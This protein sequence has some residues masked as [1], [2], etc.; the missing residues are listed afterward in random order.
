[1]AVRKDLVKEVLAEL[2]KLEDQVK[3]TG[4]YLIPFSSCSTVTSSHLEFTKHGVVRIETT[5]SIK[6]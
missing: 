1:M 2:Q 4:K 3:K 5:T 6:D